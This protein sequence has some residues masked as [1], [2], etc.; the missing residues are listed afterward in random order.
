[1]QK[2]RI[3]IN[4][5]IGIILVSYGLGSIITSIIE[6]NIPITIG[7][8]IFLVIGILLMLIKEN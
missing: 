8:F 3:S 2:L 5:I 7:G 6:K 4:V 1:M